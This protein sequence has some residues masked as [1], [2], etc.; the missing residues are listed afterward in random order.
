MIDYFF[1]SAGFLSSP[2]FLSFSDTGLSP[3]AAADGD[4]AATEGNKGDK[5]EGDDKKPAEKKSA[6]EKK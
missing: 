3:S 5:K 4:K 6:E 1:S 2:S